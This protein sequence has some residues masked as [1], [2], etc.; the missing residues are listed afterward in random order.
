MPGW[1]FKE[2][3]G[4]GMHLWARGG[5]YSPEEQPMLNPPDCHPA[6]MRWSVA[7]AA[8]A[9]RADK[10]GRPSAASWVSPAASSLAWITS[11]AFLVSLPSPLPPP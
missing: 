5:G 6:W 11:T 8:A 3:P 2:A 4:L 9:S 1:R 7:Q 10:V